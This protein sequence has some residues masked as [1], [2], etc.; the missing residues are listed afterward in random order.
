MRDGFRLYFEEI[1]M[2]AGGRRI[3]LILEDSWV[4]PAEAL[5]KLRKLV[6][7]DR[8]HV[9][10]GGLLRPTAF[11]LQ[12]YITQQKLPFVAPNMSADD[13]S[14]RKINPWLVR[15]GLNGSQTTYPMGEY[16]YQV[17]G[18]RKVAGINFDFTF[19]HESFGGFQRVFEEHG[20]QVVQRLW[21]PAAVADFAPYLALLRRD[22]DATF[23]TFAGAAALRFLKQLAEYG[24]KG[25]VPVIAQG[26]LTDE[27]VLPSMG[28]EAIGVVTTMNYSAALENPANKKFR[29]AYDE[30]RREDSLS[31][32]SHE[33]HGRPH[34]RGGAQG[35]GRRH[36]GPGTVPGRPQEAGDPR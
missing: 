18:Y 21:A 19:G 13:I 34:D 33:L 4:E 6:E 20:G 30:V 22:V 23:A 26:T 11:A 29:A 1:G 14:Q 28:D 36:R 24:I 16:A 35:R 2:Q 5:T 31:L 12:A 9:A 32:R 27:H 8:V 7:K 10:A 15:A 25:K 3:E 17:L